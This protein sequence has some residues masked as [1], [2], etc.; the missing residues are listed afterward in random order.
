MYDV[1]FQ[2]KKNPIINTTHPDSMTKDFSGTISPNLQAMELYTNIEFK[3][4]YFL[5][6]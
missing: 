6:I 4:G 5:L 1:V 2:F 3:S